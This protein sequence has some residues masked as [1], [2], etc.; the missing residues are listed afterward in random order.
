MEEH[1][2]PSVN[3]TLS[4]AELSARGAWNPQ[5]NS[6]YKCQNID[7]IIL[8]LFSHPVL[9]CPHL[10]G[11]GMAPHL[12]ER[13]KQPEAAGRQVAGKGATSTPSYYII[14]PRMEQEPQETRGASSLAGVD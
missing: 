13:L 9:G 6:P 2:F 10:L 4:V 11:T 5:T 14:D 1:G 12:Q 3:T 8:S 7:P